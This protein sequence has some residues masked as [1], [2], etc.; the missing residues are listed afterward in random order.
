MTKLTYKQPHIATEIDKQEQQVAFQFCDAYKTFLDQAKTEREAVQV[1]VEMAEKAGF[2][3][4]SWGMP[5]KSGDKIYY[6][7]RN[8]SI[9]LAVIGSAPISEG[10]RILAAHI[11]ACRLDLKQNPLYEKDELAYFK[12]H[13]YGGIKKYQ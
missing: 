13:Y 2:K 4:F 5:L 7:N 12:T 11:D 6:Q 10:V 9:I 1:T 3:P 8:K